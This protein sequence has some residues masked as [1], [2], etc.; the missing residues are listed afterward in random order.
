MERN[1]KRIFFYN[2]KLKFEGKYVNGEKTGQGKVYDYD[3]NLIYEGEYSN[4]ESE[5]SEDSN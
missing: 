1:R 4:D 5:E 3:G 2:G